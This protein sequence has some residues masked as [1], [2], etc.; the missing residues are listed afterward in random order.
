MVA[1]KVQTAQDGL[2][3][4]MLKW[5]IIDPVQLSI[6]KARKGLRSSKEKEAW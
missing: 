5:L 2:G 6:P 1:S 3:K 4:A